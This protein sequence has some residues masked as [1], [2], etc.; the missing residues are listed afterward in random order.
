[1]PICC[2]LDNGDDNHI[3]MGNIKMLSL[4]TM[5]YLETTILMIMT[6]GKKNKE[7]NNSTY[8]SLGSSVNS[9]AVR[10]VYVCA[11]S[12]GSEIRPTD[13]IVDSL[14]NRK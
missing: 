9:N 12:V 1:M 10:Y 14:P 11:Q 3:D 8:A 2:S 4:L 7:Q 5:R 6:K 13:S